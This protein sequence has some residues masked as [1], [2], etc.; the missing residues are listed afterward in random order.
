MHSSNTLRYAT[1]SVCRRYDT[2]AP[3]ARSGEVSATF[4]IRAP[5]R[6]GERL[7]IVGSTPG[8]GA[9]EPALGAP[10]HALDAGRWR[11]TVELPSSGELEDGA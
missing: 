6:A 7:Y 1:E 5:V 9:W 8:L 2:C 11:V 3:A 4:E 10:A